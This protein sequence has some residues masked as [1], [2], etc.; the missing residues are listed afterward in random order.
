[1]IIINVHFENAR[2]NNI[3]LK[4]LQLKDENLITSILLGSNVKIAFCKK[5]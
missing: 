4:M 5:A 1:M 3:K 2:A